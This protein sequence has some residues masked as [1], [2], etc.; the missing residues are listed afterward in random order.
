MNQDAIEL[1]AIEH[2]FRLARQ[3]RPP[4]KEAAPCY[5][6][7]RPYH[8]PLAIASRDLPVSSR[9]DNGFNTTIDLR[10]LHRATGWPLNTLHALTSL[11]ASL[12][13]YPRPFFFTIPS[14]I[15]LAPNSLSWLS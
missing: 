7:C 1:I 11:G 4:L 15:T 5:H 9:L 6:R 8:A 10:A 12:R 14:F 3:A 13:G 2:I